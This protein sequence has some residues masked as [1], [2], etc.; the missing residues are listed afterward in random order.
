M[1]K[2]ELEKILLIRT[3]KSKL[4]KLKFIRSPEEKTIFLRAL[5]NYEDEL[6]FDIQRKNNNIRLMQE[7][8]IETT[9][10]IIQIPLDENSSEYKDI[11]TYG[12]SA[13]PLVREKYLDNVSDSTSRNLD[14]F[15]ISPEEK[16]MI[17]SCLKKYRHELDILKQKRENNIRN[18]PD[19]YE[20]KDEYVP[21]SQN[22]LFLGIHNK[23]E[24]ENKGKNI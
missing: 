5:E 21:L 17:K 3:I 15:D 10:E 12:I 8:G 2:N 23:L 7:D 20:E 18:N 14:F 9:D 16:D 6:K 11:R 24:K 19:I 22:E 1:N 13:S 4:G